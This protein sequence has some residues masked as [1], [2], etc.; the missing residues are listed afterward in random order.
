MTSFSWMIFLCWYFIFIFYPTV[1]SVNFSF[2]L[3][4]LY[5]PPGP[6]LQPADRNPQRPGEQQE[7]AGAEPE[8]QQHRLNPQ[9]TVHQPDGLA[10]SGPKRQQAGQSATADETPGASPDSH[11][12]QQ[13]VD[14]CPAAVTQQQRSILGLKIGFEC[15]ENSQ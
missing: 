4:L 8:P 7:H 3:N 6:E 1:K 13:P 9:P 15:K 11:T 14:A 10:V 2:Y 12:E 5:S